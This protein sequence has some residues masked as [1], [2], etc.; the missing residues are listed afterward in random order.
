M[1]TELLLSFVAVAEHGGFSAAARALNRTQSAVSLQIKRLEEQ[2]GAPVFRRTSRK[3][4]LTPAGGTFLPYA[5]RLLQLQDEA[6]S[7]AAATEQAAPVRL[8]LSDEQAAAYLPTVLPAFTARF[9]AVPVEVTCDHSPA[10]IDRLQAGLLDLALV[11]RHGPTAT[12]RVVAQQPLV[13]VAAG[14]FRLDP[15]RPVQLAVNPE[16]CIYR[17]QALASLSRSNRKWRVVYTSQSSTGINIA[18]AQGMAVAVKAAR[19]VP[20]GCRVMSEA[21]GLPPLAPALIELHQAPAVFSRPAEL[22]A[23]LLLEALDGGE[24]ELV[25][26]VGRHGAHS[27]GNP[28][29]GP[30]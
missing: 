11:V 1:N 18:V 21:E 8:G 24:T 9:P 2:L 7:A 6:M 27:T 12:G 5:R 17:A 19:S 23:Q 3:I 28:E 4:E 20:P 25:A 10:L 26:A 29:T 14:D 30:A 16:G 15:A 13:W 22:I